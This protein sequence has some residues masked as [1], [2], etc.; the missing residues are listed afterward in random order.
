MDFIA[1]CEEIACEVK[2]AIKGLVGSPAGGEYMGMGADGT[3]T[4]RIDKV[5]EDCVVS[6]LQHNLLA[7]VLVSEELGR[8]EIGGN[9]GT[10]FL[11]PIDGTF[12]A[13]SGIPFF[14]L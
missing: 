14:A 10:I 11:D 4:K 3:P 12:N 1:S 2:G 6:Y 5:A 9:K 13:V 7:K 8:R